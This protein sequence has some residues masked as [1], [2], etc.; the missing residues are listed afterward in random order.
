MHLRVNNKYEN[1]TQVYLM[2]DSIFSGIVQT[3]LSMLLNET[4]YTELLLTINKNTGMELQSLFTE[5]ITDIC[6]KA[7]PRNPK[8][9]TITNPV[10]NASS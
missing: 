1:T 3:L 8:I 4:R 5:T 7:E 2:S 9:R 6:V 10:G